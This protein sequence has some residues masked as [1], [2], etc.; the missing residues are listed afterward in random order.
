MFLA[1]D[2]SW[3]MGLKWF[4]LGMFVVDVNRVVTCYV[5]YLGVGN[6]NRIKTIFVQKKITTKWELRDEKKFLLEI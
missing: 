5:L 2:L 3:V 1:A 4:D 6:P